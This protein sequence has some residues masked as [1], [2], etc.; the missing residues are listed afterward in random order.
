MLLRFKYCTRSQCCCIWLICKTFQRY[1]SFKMYKGLFYLH[2]YNIWVKR[3]VVSD[4][5]L[6]DSLYM[7][8]YIQFNLCCSFANYVLDLP[9]K[10]CLSS[11]INVNWKV[12]LLRHEHNRENITKYIK[13][14]VA[15]L[16]GRCFVGRT[17]I[18]FPNSF[19]QLGMSWCY[20]FIFVY[21]QTTCLMLCVGLIFAN[22]LKHFSYQS[23]V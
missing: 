10:V 13:G 3:F 11:L 14:S 8:M 2:D 7:F 23:M 19:G 1:A 4:P 6:P 21:T 12:R 5:E 20:F 16:Y 22:N 17:H 9:I 18:L 15:C